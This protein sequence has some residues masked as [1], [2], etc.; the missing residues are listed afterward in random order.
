[1][2]RSKNI[3]LVTMGLIPVALSA[4]D[5]STYT[6]NTKVTKTFESFS[7]CKSQ[8]VPEMVCSENFLK[9]NRDHLALAPRYESKDACES[10]FEKDFCIE[11]KDAWIPKMA[12]FQ[13]TR[14]GPQTFSRETGEMVSPHHGSSNDGLLTGILIGQMMSGGRNVN[15][16]S[17]PV[18]M[19][20]NTEGEYRRSTLRQRISEGQKFEG[21]KTT[22]TRSTLRNAST[23]STK[24]ANTI[25]SRPAP[26]KSSS[27][28]ASGSTGRYGSHANSSSVSR[29]GFG[30]RASAK[31]G[32]GSFGG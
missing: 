25:A 20:R 1:M 30:S 9:A 14:E 27:T 12:G 15:Y 26:S 24:A 10:D 13:I 16:Y 17:E 28:A 4:C 5:N 18:Y 29:S 3:R 23:T 22:P 11:Q 31:S 6:Q 7:D 19:G 21:A 32:F 8:G 2:K